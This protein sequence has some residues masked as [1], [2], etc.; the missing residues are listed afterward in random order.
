MLPYNS[1]NHF[2]LVAHDAEVT[3]AAHA[4]L[5]ENSYPTIY[6][7]MIIFQIAPRSMK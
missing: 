5:D 6:S 3:R 2:D 4:E 1:C 7:S